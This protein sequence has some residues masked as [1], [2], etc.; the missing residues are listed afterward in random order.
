MT[1]LT[2]HL[3]S[4]IEGHRASHRR[5]QSSKPTNQTRPIEFMI[6]VTSI[7]AFEE[8]CFQYCWILSLLHRDI[9][10]QGSRVSGDVWA[11]GAGQKPRALG[12]IMELCPPSPHPQTN[13]MVGVYLA[14][15]LFF[16]TTIR[17]FFFFFKQTVLA[18]QCTDTFTQSSAGS[19]NGP[20]K[21]AAPIYR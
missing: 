1:G 10:S 21:A 17:L 18:I 15:A 4:C 6:K 13:L 12:H 2:V 19:L 20:H 3:V 8:T 9:W 11:A 7:G 16:K 14:A 5:G